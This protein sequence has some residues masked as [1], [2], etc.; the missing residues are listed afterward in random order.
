MRRLRQW[1]KLKKLRALLNSQLSV[2]VACG[3]REQNALDT[4]VSNLSRPCGSLN[5]HVAASFRFHLQAAQKKLH[6]CA[7]PA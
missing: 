7:L 5:G 3:D 4:F 1:K 2:G 6:D